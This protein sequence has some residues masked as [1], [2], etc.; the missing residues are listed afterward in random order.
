MVYPVSVGG[1]LKLFDDNREAK[2]F[3]L[4]HSHAVDNGVIIL[5]YQ[6]VH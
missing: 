1:G 5:E 4:K 6:A 3:E 2:K